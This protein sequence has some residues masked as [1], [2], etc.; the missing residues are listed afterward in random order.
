MGM[1]V[2]NGLSRF[3]DDYPGMSTAPCL[4]A[5]VCLRGKFRFTASVSGS[6]VIEDFYV[7]EIIVPDGFPQALPK[8][9]EI[10][11]KIL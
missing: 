4:D 3:L 1:K 2:I 10:D 11:G 9:K 6:N 5:G 7:L 8:V